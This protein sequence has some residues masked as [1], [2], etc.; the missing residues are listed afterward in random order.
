MK[1][2]INLVVFLILFAS[3]TFLFAKND[4]CTITCYEK[5]PTCYVAKNGKDCLDISNKPIKSNGELVCELKGCESKTVYKIE[6]KAT[7]NGVK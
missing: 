1:P 3:P 4:S 2:S 6:D 5:T 7:E